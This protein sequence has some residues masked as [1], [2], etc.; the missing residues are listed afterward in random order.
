M[1]VCRRTTSHDRQTPCRPTSR[2]RLEDRGV[3]ERVDGEGCGYE[4]IWHR[5]GPDGEY[6]V[7]ASEDEPSSQQAYYA[8]ALG[9]KLRPGLTRRQLGELMQDAKSQLGGPPTREQ[10]ALAKDWQLEIPSNAKRRDLTDIL[11]E[12]ILAQIWVMSVCR[13][14]AGARWQRHADSVVRLTASMR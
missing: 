5:T 8:I 1:D 11:Y 7:M 9:V 6:A 14:I 13:K 10:I 4:P 12:C 2:S 3:E